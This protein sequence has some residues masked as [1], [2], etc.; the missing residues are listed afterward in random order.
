MKLYRRRREEQEKAERAA[1]GDVPVPTREL[2]AQVRTKIAFAIHDAAPEDTYNI[3][4]FLYFDTV[5]KTLTRAW[6]EPSLS[7]RAGAAEDLLVRLGDTKSSS[8]EVVEMIEA[9]L[10]A[11]ETFVQTAAKDWFEREDCKTKANQFRARINDILDE[12]D[13]AFQVVGGE[14]VD[15]ESMAL[16]ANVVAPVVSL[17]HG[18]PA[19]ANVE[20][21][22][23]AA[24]RELKPG[25]TPADAIT[26]AATALQEMLSALGCS[27]NALG[28]LL[29]DA[30][31]KGLLGPYDS[32]L[33][34]G[35][36]SIGEWL[37]ADRSTRGDAHNADE[38]MREDAWLA[39]HVAGALVTRLARR[40]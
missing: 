32:K 36:E 28:P 4:P 15:R 16:H 40:A 26:D 23:Q 10:G 20:A 35:I 29:D 37:N 2:S 7:G 33:A 34:R 30:K 17:L 39:V 6:G 38:A 31:K 27:G 14:V 3:G 25:G 18:E 9:A 13:I 21:A 22:F 5:R 19:F 24:L 11:L 12:H 8:E 1:R